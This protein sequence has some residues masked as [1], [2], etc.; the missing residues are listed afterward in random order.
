MIKDRH[1][2]RYMR[3]RNHCSRYYLDRHSRFKFLHDNFKGKI[4]FEGWDTKYSEEEIVEV[5]GILAHLSVYD[6]WKKYSR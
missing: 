4:S 2:G 3:W 5:G 1:G 6:L